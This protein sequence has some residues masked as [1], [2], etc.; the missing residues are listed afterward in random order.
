M[1]DQVNL[2]KKL[3]ITALLA[4][5]VLVGLLVLKGGNAIDIA[6]DLSNRGSI[7]IDFSMEKDFT[8][9]EMG[10]VRN[11]INGLLNR[12]FNN[13]GL[14]VFDTKFAER[15]KNMNDEVKAFW[16]GY[17]VN[18][19]VIETTKYEN[20]GG[21]LEKSRRNAIPISSSNST[22]FEVDISK[23]EYVADKVARDV[24]GQII[25][26]YSPVML[27]LEKIRALCQQNARYIDV[28]YSMTAKS[29]ARDFYDIHN[30][31]T[32]FA[33]KFDSAADIEILSHIFQAKK[34]PLSY[35]TELADQYDLHQSSWDSV[36]DTIDVNE[37]PQQFDYYFNFVNE[38]AKRLYLQ[39][40]GVE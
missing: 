30:L 40:T 32:S 13:N 11:Q 28:V 4:D 24:G 6:Y 7:D 5:E 34:V 27:A 29:R 25:Y 35:L 3:T 39:A 12:E 10:Y 26:V 2:I 19:K 15:P 20:F 1:N 9:E 17:N 16:G 33:L 36:L 38:I 23:Y 31:A 37:K 21:D 14:T 8:E 22:V 18:F